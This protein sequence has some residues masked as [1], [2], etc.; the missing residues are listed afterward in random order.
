MKAKKRGSIKTQLILT[1][2]LL[3]A[4]PLI[5]AVVISAVSSINM[6]T[7]NQESISAEKA[8]VVSSE[9]DTLITSSF[10]MLRSVASAAPV[11]Q[12][13]EDPTNETALADVSFTMKAVDANVNDGNYMRLVD[14]TGQQVFR[15]DD[16]E[17]ISVDAREYFKQS[18]AGNEFVSEVLESK[19]T[20]SYIIVLSVPVKDASGNVIGIIHRN[21][22]LDFVEEIIT[23]EADSLT[24]INIVDREALLIDGT[25]T[26]VAVGEDRPDYSAS[27]LVTKALAGE[28]GCSVSNYTG[29]K[30]LVAYTMNES[31]G[32]AVVVQVDYNGAMSS[33]HQTINLIIILGAVLL[34]V[35]AFVGLKIANSFAKPITATS[36]LA[37]ELAKGNLNADDVKVKSNNEIAEMA[38]AVND[39]RSRLSD[40]IKNTKVSSKDVD[41]ESIS[42]SDNA[43]QASEAASQVSHA[44]DEISRGAVSQAESVQTAAGNTTS[45]GDDIDII[46]GNVE[47]LNE[48]SSDMRKSCNKAMETLS[49]LI[50]QSNEVTQSVRDIGD[51]INST[52]SSAKQI[53]EFTEAISN[54]A[55]QT[56]LLSL[57]ASIEAARAGEAG[58]GFA[59]VAQEISSLAEESNQSASM[60]KEIV[61]GLLENSA[62]SVDVMEKL[63]ENFGKQAEQLETTKSTMEDMAE[64]VSNVA[65]S[66]KQISEKIDSLET[67]KNELT[68]IITDL[69]AISEENAASTQ[70]TN[71]SMEELNATF[72]LIS[73]SA[74]KLQHLANDLGQNISYFQV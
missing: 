8:Q 4:I 31:T 29:Q 53:S 5:L 64:S 28:S 73:D 59:V 39:M 60:I 61:D 33:T 47:Q 3:S 9:I 13:L 72:Q 49:Q 37:G 32:W 41:N 25:T 35:A 63:N 54:I 2:I 50:E 44:I 51:T 20:G 17:L 24:V 69:S 23:E 57:N 36:G 12:Y 65:Q 11:V 42:L 16:G 27:S 74:K 19:T 21:Y 68:H 38:D 58:K 55:D 40:V 7:E 15:S 26:D 6:A 30:S 62:Q 43:S 45:I 10:S 52:N 14:A 56:N 1:M 34:I 71:A 67:A 48:Y 22:D 70:E 66:S 46:S 18:M